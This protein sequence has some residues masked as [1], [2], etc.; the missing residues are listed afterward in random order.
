MNSN[1]LD[2]V[3]IG[4]GAAGIAAARKLQS[5]GVDYVMLEARDRLG[6]RAWT[7][8]G[9]DGVSLDFGCGWLHS[10]DVNPWSEIARHQGLAIDETRPPWERPPVKTSLEGESLSGF[11]PALEDFRQR[12][13]DWPADAP[14]R[15]ASDFLDPHCRWNPLIDAVSTYYSGAES[16][17]ISARDLAR[18]ADNGLNWRVVDGYGRAVALYGSA[19]NVRLNCVVDRIDHSGPGVRIETSNGA[20][21]ARAAIVALPSALIARAETLFYPVIADK[22]AAAHDLPLGLADKLFLELQDAEAFEAD[23]RA[24]GATGRTDTAAYHFRPF[25]RPL[26]EAYFGGACALELER[27]GEQAFFAF[28]RAELKGLFGADF[29]RRIKPLPMHRWAMDPFAGGSYSYA[30]PGKADARRRLAASVADKLFFAGEACS[31]HDYSTAHGAFRTGVE[32]ADEALIA[33]GRRA[34]LAVAQA[35]PRQS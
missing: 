24:F 20:L 9:S 18:Y 10:A 7:V 22:T 35:S 23:S 30:S 19:L 17:L 21:K 13:E 4:G 28:A 29:Q 1:D 26:I 25:G 6:G 12:I 11:G 2:V 14:D 15:P 34:G 27:Q 32:A 5:V 33:L 8:K 31:V 16:S 3:V